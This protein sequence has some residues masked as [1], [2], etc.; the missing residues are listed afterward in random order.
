MPQP[1]DGPDG[2]EDSDDMMESPSPDIDDVLTGGADGVP[3]ESEPAATDDL[4]DLSPSPSLDD[5][6]EDDDD[7]VCF[8]ANALVELENGATKMM[9][10]VQL[11]DR[12]RVGP[13]D[14]SDVFM[15]T[16]KTAA[17]KY[18]F[19]TLATQSGH[20]LSLT[21]GHYL[22]VNGVVAAA[23]TVRSGDFITLADG[24]TSSVTQVGTEIARGLYNPQTV[25][26]DI[27]VNGLLATTYT[28]TVERSMAHALL[29]PL[30]AVYSSIGW[31]M[32]ALDAGA[33]RLAGIVPSG[34][35]VA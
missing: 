6:G 21:K 18:S 35:V 28:T 9:S 15:F 26:G 31:S 7:S 4:S 30:R 2:M 16:H 29:A 23:K 1:S 24:T 17:I 3:G 14:F 13:N 19:V 22:Y 32:S 27:I 8:P 5:E 11:G 20:T 33:D 10:Q 12:V 34:S 25:H